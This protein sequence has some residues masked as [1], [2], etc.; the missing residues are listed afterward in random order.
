MEEL[1]IT[2]ERKRQIDEIL[3]ES[4]RKYENGGIKSVPLKVFL[5]RNKKRWG[6]LHENICELSRLN[7]IRMPLC[8][9]S[10]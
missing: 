8:V 6:W 2:Q 1:N 5:E 9:S 10:S 4:Q 7:A 3:K